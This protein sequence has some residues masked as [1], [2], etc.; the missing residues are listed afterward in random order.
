MLDPDTQTKIEQVF[1]NS[2]SLNQST[3]V[4][5]MNISTNDCNREIEP[6]QNHQLQR[7]LLN[8]E[9]LLN[10]HDYCSPNKH[11]KQNDCETQ[12]KKNTDPPPSETNNDQRIQI[13]LA[14]TSSSHTKSKSSCSNHNKNFDGENVLEATNDHIDD[15]NF[16]DTSSSSSSLSSEDSGGLVIADSRPKSLAPKDTPSVSRPK[17]RHRQSSLKAGTDQQKQQFRQRRPRQNDSVTDKSQWITGEEQLDS[18][19]SE[20]LSADRRE[21]RQR[22]EVHDPD[23]SHFTSSEYSS[24][25]A[26]SDDVD[27][28][29]DENDPNRPWCICMKPHGDQ[30]MICCDICEYWYHGMC[31][32]VTEKMNNRFVKEK[33][34][35]FCGECQTHL[36]S[37]TPREAI[38]KKIVTKPKKKKT[39]RGGKRPRGRPRRSDVATRESA[40]LSSR[41]AAKRTNTSSD[42]KVATKRTKPDSARS[43]SFEEFANTERLQELIKERKKAFFFKRSLANQQRAAKLK[44]MGIGRQPITAPLGNSLDSLASSTSSSNLNSLPSNTSKLE[45][46]ER[47]K[48]N[49]VLQINTKRDGGVTAVVKSEK[50]KHFESTDHNVDDMFTAEP[51]QLHNQSGSH[52]TQSQQVPIDGQP[53]STSDRRIS[54]D[55]KNNEHH[56][57][58][59]PKKRRKDSESSTTT[60]FGSKE[61]AEKIRVCL[62][63]RAKQ[64]KDLELPSPE[65]IEA[66]SSE[67]EGQLNENFKEGSPKYLNKYRS[68]IF[69]LRDTKNQALVKNVLTGEIPPARLVKMSPDEMASHELAKWRERENKHSIELIKRDA[70]LAAQQVI[71]KKTHKGEEVISAPALND[72]DDP[73]VEV[74]KHEPPT[75]PTKSPSKDNSIK[76]SPLTTAS[77]S[78]TDKQESS[79]SA[80]KKLTIQLPPPKAVT[81][82]GISIAESLPFL[83]TTKDHV[84]K[85]HLFDINCKICTKQKVEEDEASPKDENR[86]VTPSSVEADSTSKDEQPS[87]PKRLRVSMESSLDLSHLNRLRDQPLITPSEKP[88]DT[89]EFSPSKLTPDIES[90]HDEDEDLY[91]PE[92]MDTKVGSEPSQNVDKMDGTVWSGNITMLDVGKLAANATRVSGDPN[93]MSDGISRNLLVCG[94]IKPEQVNLYIKKLKATTKNQIVSIEFQPKSET[95][96]NSYETLFD[97]L[98]TRNRCGVIDN[99]SHAQILKDFYIIPIHEGG[100]IPEV[101]KPI[102]GPG[103][104]RGHKNCLLGVMVKTKHTTAAISGDSLSATS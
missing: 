89:G 101:L 73:T 57:T 43:E 25:D 13:P 20:H 53:P 75:T 79:V 39:G 78:T 64:L 45:H 12:A 32:G 68:L 52:A 3:P 50:R 61:I 88:V 104:A 5:A 1:D 37:G 17:P 65:K 51:I 98:Y 35:W 14:S 36:Q 47:A 56:S 70:Q 38:P 9:S 90:N 84:S 97:Y 86:V 96:K 58:T 23:F 60:S 67:I 19:L 30:F 34:E 95:D 102:Q 81:T 18:A 4:N 71:V 11:S 92:T 10:D 27:S 41:I 82:S 29:D 22:K 26:Q 99:S 55:S 63:T 2:A 69:N 77:S 76:V 7:K 16:S 93:F 59:T 15:G 31:V 74:N 42:S 91:D 66:L 33:K 40:R 54:N 24:S 80:T 28:E 6:Q 87:E 46:T 83:D 8:A 62:E 44:E 72:P 48:P 94:R 103:L 100:S 21:R 85:N 49:I